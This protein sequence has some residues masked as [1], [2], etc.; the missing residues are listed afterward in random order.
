MKT[1]YI[2]ISLSGGAGAWG[3]T[4]F[5]PN[6][7]PHVFGERLA[8]QEAAGTTVAELSATQ[9]AVARLEASQRL[10]ANDALEI[11]MRSTAALSVLRWVFPEAPVESAGP[12]HTPKKMASATK[13]LPALYDLHETVER[14][15]LKVHLRHVVPCDASAAAQDVARSHV[16]RCA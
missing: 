5:A 1:L 12:I 16:R 15:G 9:A 6:A 2:E 7:R 14:L 4:F 3:A 8:A 13:T 10:L 11:A